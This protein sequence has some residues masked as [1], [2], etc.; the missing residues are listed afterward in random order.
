[1]EK[2]NI[3]RPHF[4]ILNES[5]R[6]QIHRDSLHILSSIGVRVDSDDAKQIFRKK[7]GS[8]AVQGD[9]VYIPK[10]VVEYAINAAPAAVDIYNR[11]GEHAFHLPG[12]AR[13][14]IGVTVLNYQDP[15]TDQVQTFT[16]KHMASCVRLGDELANFDTV[17]TIGIVQDVPVEIADMYATLEMTANTSKPLVLLVSK[18]DSFATVLDLL[19]LLHGDLSSK[20]FIIPLLSPVT[21]LVI[22][23]EMAANMRESIARGLPIIYSNHGMAGANTPILPVG[24]FLQLIAELLAGLTL[25]QLIKEGT[26]VL[27]GAEPSFFD[28]RG[29][30]FYYDPQ[31]YLINL[32]LAEMMAYYRVPSYGTSGGSMGWDADL[33]AAGHQWMNHLM[34][35]MRNVGLATFVGVNQGFLVFSPALAVYANEVIAQA[36]MFASGFALDESAL[37]I[38]EIAKV[39]PGGHFL[40]SDLTL[41]R[42]RQASFSSAIF[43]ELTLEEWQARGCPKTDELLKEYT[44]RL[45]ADSKRPDDYEHLMAK[46][47]A[48]IKKIPIQKRNYN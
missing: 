2:G 25:S 18:D 16:R 14:G 10:E 42:C 33:V 9:R 24:M 22:T 7:I 48:F 27:L 35:C 32:A 13:F 43:P 12:K 5:Q 17:A 11:K 38:E 4:H 29:G 44:I 23:G 37:A 31:S 34:S 36:R 3:A 30:G 19:E 46:G 15:E 28:M 20:P 41:D 40:D 39:G 6:E 26:P 21:P 8:S 45:M 1:M 47:E